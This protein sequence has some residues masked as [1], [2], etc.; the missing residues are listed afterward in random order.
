[1][2]E[3]PEVIVYTQPGC[4]PCNAVKEFLTQNNIDFI[5]KDIRLDP[6]ALKELIELGA[7]ATPATK[8][9]D[10]VIMGFDVKRLSDALGLS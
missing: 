3:A 4:T 2:S 7:M 6:V 9:G 1:M 10:K 8:I 5:E